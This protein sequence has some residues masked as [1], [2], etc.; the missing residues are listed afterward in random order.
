MKC[1][2][3]YKNK[4]YSESDFHELIAKNPEEF[5]MLKDNLGEDSVT[6]Q[7]AV[8]YLTSKIGKINIKELL[9]EEDVSRNV[10]FDD[11]YFL[12]RDLMLSITAPEKQLFGTM[13]NGGMAFLKNQNGISK[14]VLKHETFHKIFNYYLTKNERDTLIQNYKKANPQFVNLSDERIEE[15]MAIEF[16]TYVVTGKQKSNPIL[17]FFKKLLMY[18]KII[19]FKDVKDLFEAIEEG[20]FK[21]S[22]PYFSARIRS[23]YYDPIRRNSE[24]DIRAFGI[25][26]YKQAINTIRNV[27]DG[28]V[29]EGS[30]ADTNRDFTPP[31]SERE[32]YMATWNEMVDAYKY[33]RSIVDYYTKPI[34]NGEKISQ[35]ERDAYNYS[36]AT[37][38]LFRS[39]IETE[40]TV[41]ED[42]TPG[43]TKPK[44]FKA[45]FQDAFPMFNISSGGIFKLEEDK[46]FMEELIADY[47]E[48]GQPVFFANIV[49]NDTVN[50]ESKITFNVKTY[51]SSIK[52]SDGKQVPHR[53]AFIISSHLLRNF[54]WNQPKQKLVEKIN[55]N[56]NLIGGSNNKWMQAVK[57]KLLQII[58]QADGEYWA[59]DIDGSKSIAF[60]PEE[61]KNSIKFTDEDTV[62]VINPENNLVL[63]KIDNFTDH[64][65]NNMY[66]ELQVLKFTRNKNESTAD[67]IERIVKESRYEKLSNFTLSNI[68]RMYQYKNKMAEI[69]STFSSMYLQ[70]LYIVK[71]E[72]K[73]GQLI[74]TYQPSVSISPVMGLKSMIEQLLIKNY[75]PDKK[76]DLNKTIS[77]VKDMEPGYKKDKLRRILV[78]INMPL[79]LIDHLLDDKN[80]DEI[81]IS[82]IL[83]GFN[84]LYDAYNKYLNIK[85]ANRVSIAAIKETLDDTQ[86]YEGLEE[87]DQSPG[88]IVPEEDDEAAQ[89][90][91]VDINWLIANK[92]NKLTRAIA[93]NIDNVYPNARSL[94]IKGAEGKTKHLNILSNNG[95]DI[96]SRMV[97]PK[98][99]GENKI[100]NDAKE[101]WSLFRR[102]I[103]ANRNIIG[104]NEP[105]ISEIIDHDGIIF[106]DRAT[107]FSREIPNDWWSRV[108]NASFIDEL[109]R[110]GN[111]KTDKT[112]IHHLI[113]VDRP[114]TIGVRL[115]ILKPDEIKKAIDSAIRQIM[116][117]P[118]IFFIPKYKKDSFLNFEV[119]KR[120]AAKDSKS[121]A[122]KFVQNPSK[123]SQ[124]NI[125]ALVNEIYNEL[126]VMSDELSAY[127]MK[128]N[129]TMTEK[130]DK[131]VSNIGGLIDK[132]EN[133]DND[134]KNLF[135][136]FVRN[137][138]INSYFLNQSLSGDYAFFGNSATFIKRFRAVFSP[139]T[140]PV[141][142][143]SFGMKETFRAMIITN[144]D[145][146]KVAGDV[147]RGTKLEGVEFNPYDGFAVITPERMESL[148]EG[149]GRAYNLGSI[150]KPITFDIV[151]KTFIGVDGK[152][153]TVQIPV[154][155]KYATFVLTDELCNNFKSSL[156]IIRDNM[157]RNDIDEVVFDSAIK[158]GI[159]DKQFLVNEADMLSTNLDIKGTDIEK[160]SVYT[161]KNEN[162]RIQLNPIRHDIESV[163]NPSQLTYFINLLGS[164]TNE[165]AAGK[166]YDYMGR[167][168]ARGSDRI[169]E[170]LKTEADV[171]KMILEAKT[172]DR[173]R[174]LQEY[175]QEGLF[176]NFPT[177]VNNIFTQV[178]SKITEETVR[179]RFPGD[180]LILH[181]DWA[182]EV[183]IDGVKRRLMYKIKNGRLVTEVLVNKK[184]MDM[185]K[186]GDFLYGDAFGFRLPSSEL[187][188]AVV[189]EVV[190]YHTE[191]T[192][193]IIAPREIVAHHGSDFD[194]DSL[195]VIRRALFDKEY[196][197]IF[198]NGIYP[199]QNFFEKG[200]PVGYKVV[201]QKKGG[202][203]YIIDPDF[204]TY[205]DDIIDEIN[206]S[207]WSDEKKKQQRDVIEEIRDTYYKNVIIDAFMEFLSSDLRNKDRILSPILMDMF[208]GKDDKKQLKDGTVLKALEDLGVDV[209]M[210]YDLSNPMDVFNAYRAIFEG[211]SLVG[212]FA[213]SMKSLAYAFK[214]ASYGSEKI[215]NAINQTRKDL[216]T[217]KDEAKEEELNTQLASLLNQYNASIKNAQKS[218]SLKFEGAK[219]SF[220]GFTY[221]TFS[222]FEL[223]NGEVT[224]ESQDTLSIWTILDAMLNLSIDNQ[225]E[226]VMFPINCSSNTFKAYIGL[227]SLGVPIKQAV[228]FMRNPI[229]LQIN[230]YK[231]VDS[232]LTELMPKV[233]PKNT[234][235]LNTDTVNLTAEELELS[236]SKTIKSI[237]DNTFDLSKATEEEKLLYYK[238]LMI[239][240]SANKIGDD[241]STFAM[242][243]SG[244]LN[245]KNKPEDLRMNESAWKKIGLVDVSGSNKILVTNPEFSFNLNTLFKNHPH[246]A[247]AMKV[248]NRTKS[249][250][251]KLFFRYSQSAQILVEAALPNIR[252][253]FFEDINI[254]RLEDEALKYIVSASADIGN[255][256]PIQAGD[257]ILKGA[258]AFMEHFARKISAL[259][260]SDAFKG[261][262]FVDKLIV[263]PNT[264]GSSSVKFALGANTTYDDLLELETAFME[265]NRYKYVYDPETQQ[266]EIET[267]QAVSVFSDEQREFISYGLL[268]N[269][270]SFGAYNYNNVIPPKLFM[271]IA[272]K[273][274]KDINQLM[275]ETKKN[276]KD[277]MVA[278]RL[279]EDFT[280]AVVANYPKYVPFKPKELRKSKTQS[281]SYDLTLFSNEEMEVPKYVRYGELVYKLET[282]FG[283]E[284]FYNEINPTP[285]RKYYISRDLF[286]GKTTE[287]PQSTQIKE[288]VPELFESNPELS[289]S[290][291]ETL[292][293]KNFS[294][295]EKEQLIEQLRNPLFDLIR[296]TEL[297]NKYKGETIPYGYS[298]NSWK[299]LVSGINESKLD[300]NKILSVYKKRLLEEENTPIRETGID[301]KT[302][303]P[304]GFNPSTGQ[305]EGGFGE[306]SE[307]E[308]AINKS[309]QKIAVLEKFINQKQQAQQLY[310]QYLDTGKQDIE[311]FK[312]FVQ[313]SNLPEKEFKKAYVDKSI[314]WSELKDLPVYSEK[315]VMVMR[316]QGTHEH[317]GNP[318]TFLKSGVTGLI[319]TKDIQN[320]VDAYEDWLND[321]YVI[322]S[323][324]N[325][326]AQEIEEGFK[327]EQ[328]DWI[329]SQ[330]EQGKLDG[331]KL[332]Y[333]KETLDDKKGYEGD[334][335]SH[336]DALADIVNKRM[337]TRYRLKDNNQKL[338]ETYTDEIQ[339]QTDINLQ[340][341]LDQITPLMSEP[342]LELME[343][344]PKPYIQTTFD[345]T[346]SEIPGM[347]T[348][349]DNK[350][351]VTISINEQSEIPT[352]FI[353]EYVHALTELDLLAF[354]NGTLTDQ[355]KIEAIMN[356]YDAY[357]LVTTKYKSQ[358]S[359][360]GLTSVNEF[361][362]EFYANKEFRQF[363]NSI[364]IETKSGIKTLLR[365]IYDTILKLFNIKPNTVAASVLENSLI[366]MEASPQVFNK[367][368]HRL[369]VSEQ[370]MESVK[371][372]REKMKSI[373]DDTIDEYINYC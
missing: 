356:L 361:I 215:V 245:P 327:K 45:L 258:D 177:I 316:K 287:T 283:R 40:Q 238:V 292:G 219:I 104:S 229:I 140:K 72:Y 22:L 285:N 239:F 88:N 332:L 188:S 202:E 203:K 14:Q 197:F 307:K 102:N 3:T 69:G 233:L 155:L 293:F 301:E 89:E 68:F 139:G 189:M 128:N 184:F 50:R 296:G 232:A 168:I 267:T 4:K 181:A 52:T 241:I 347:I 336:A 18:F 228:L 268:S 236:I 369:F 55:E 91:K 146:V 371:L 25:R 112:Y 338:Q 9:P 144:D 242:A 75:R 47:D 201:N 262:M 300:L 182:I 212:K 277:N 180:D 362:S 119:V 66:Q 275:N 352:T 252:I 246:I 272:G 225:K 306:I 111:N 100:Y 373:S 231:N 289:N 346:K 304:K 276:T 286:E 37:L 118:D 63:E 274:S 105:L 132:N 312:E 323:D 354:E 331:Q 172:T 226:G 32:L 324:K 235:G 6:F 11:V 97:N 107:P 130:L 164:R 131:A 77:K 165:K 81:D 360:Y 56:L 15:K 340:S 187:H 113:P 57:D 125:N 167:L 280:D 370:E 114:R 53:F 337:Q 254:T 43:I 259:K 90:I 28:L 342:E 156:G 311:G 208:N 38:P 141:I 157:Y 163:A 138:Y 222:D 39:I 61:F 326:V 322:Y 48:E 21:N 269:G 7:E 46:I 317:F 117:R 209:D 145:K 368:P 2:I 261:N 237:Q 44:Y 234:E 218:S 73:D 95:M 186:P 16:Q 214:S 244:I 355:R 357:N 178:G 85:K 27:V 108:L 318:F 271:E 96:L 31:V 153:I 34:A 106:N 64:K 278:Q 216:L 51:L 266:Y 147:F 330:I 135:R 220:N 166:V 60:I 365:H 341:A 303:L 183:E 8:K 211:R 78:A 49:E 213:N 1:V 101:G 142:N 124:K 84:S 71:K 171:K 364:Q 256:S 343:I 217:V 321:D 74:F 302:G 243:V 366:L 23:S 149:I 103:F 290:V 291:Y 227:T 191:D 281:K 41:K 67:F 288:G 264:D 17:N 250:Y 279:V 116:E 136:L 249:L 87:T 59:R 319:Q 174:R 62:Y 185:L 83:L 159:P 194:I 36:V 299:L 151:E 198:N 82:N 129:I 270:L 152:E 350:A 193:S 333:M 223:H 294:N 265:L 320:A 240:K 173:N 170:K 224:K 110:P 42:G 134:Y 298:E 325:G 260:T 328:R 20:H 204:D 99:F 76:Q 251:K 210:E 19:Q 30:E 372:M 309:K 109:T 65:L 92:F 122:A 13:I 308:N 255:P 282:T 339:S 205:L 133:I 367:N 353:H 351:K 348:I 94:S 192:N 123:F 26:K 24:M 161:M 230:N 137:Y 206:N 253:D 195:W 143:R 207:N 86:G 115:K 200:E 334:Y 148:S 199:G 295:I 263:K 79:D 10:Q 221:D 160:Y 297:Y 248:R 363:L 121:Q 175:L 310:S 98:R 335:Y 359:F 358:V 196:D 162:Y 314:S 35:E 176:I 12:E 247:E 54:D 127:L 80:A 158:V 179:M 345:F 70:N 126:G 154:L 120:I 329:L 257:K 315:G 313:G 349:A 169:F 93:T 58:A 305:F 190:G 29:S 150:L 344:L 284:Y 33:H 5:P 273:M